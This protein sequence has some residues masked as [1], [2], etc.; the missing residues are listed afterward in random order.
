MAVSVVYCN[1]EMNS[2]DLIPVRVGFSLIEKNNCS[3]L[4]PRHDRVGT[5]RKK[6]VMVELGESR[7]RDQSCEWAPE[8]PLA[9]FLFKTLYIFLII[10]LVRI[11][12]AVPFSL[13]YVTVTIWILGW[14]QVFRLYLYLWNL[15]SPNVVCQG[16]G[17]SM[18]KKQASLL[19][20]VSKYSPK[21]GV[22][23]HFWVVQGAEGR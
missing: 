4:N 9:Y 2:D 1:V 15:L 11:F 17:W 18:C 16:K 22:A 21:G 12:L 13:V 7:P 3:R 6:A 19:M 5:T 23:N 8:N 20:S 10:L 14:R